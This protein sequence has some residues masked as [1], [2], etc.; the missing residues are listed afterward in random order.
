MPIA[1]GTRESPSGKYLA[2]I[3]LLSVSYSLC[4]TQ[5]IYYEGTLIP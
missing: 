4:S 3:I 1:I 2:G 5:V